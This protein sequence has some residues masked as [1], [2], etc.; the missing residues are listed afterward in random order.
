MGALAYLL[1]LT[2]VALL[3]GVFAPADPAR[4]DLVHRLDG[5]SWTHWL[6][7]DEFGRDVLSRMIFAS[8]V[9]LLAGIEATG[10]ALVAGTTLGI[11]AAYVGRAVDAL[12]SR[13]ADALMSLPPVILALTVV[14]ALGPGL[15]NAMIAIGI[16][17]APR[18]FRVARGSTLNVKHQLFIEAGRTSGCSSA[19]IMRCYVLPSIA[20]ALLVQLSFNVGT[21]IIAEASL[22]FLGLGIQPPDA[23]W[24]SMLSDSFRYI[25]RASF[26]I[27]PP[28]VMITLTILAFSTLGDAIRDAMGRDSRTSA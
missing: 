8:R 19:R 12:L 21:A 20:S 9:A 11:V 5:P 25:R 16:I 22:S 4:Q 23:S 10:I 27:I 1:V 6:G 14:G 3:A 15:T 7:T 13:T 24:G 18:F 17:L 26:L 2:T 28:T